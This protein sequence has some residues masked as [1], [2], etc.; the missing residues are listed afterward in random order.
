MIETQL[1]VVRLT[2]VPRRDLGPDGYAALGE[3][4]VD[5]ADATIE[6]ESLDSIEVAVSRYGNNILV[7]Y[8][9]V[10]RKSL[11]D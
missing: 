10:T 5:E 4:E 2:S 7:H 9:N 11:R 8:G 1:C 6:Q 3:L